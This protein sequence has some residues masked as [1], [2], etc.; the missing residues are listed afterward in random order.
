M[1]Y[2]QIENV[3]KRAWLTAWLED[4]TLAQHRQQ[5]LLLSLEGEKKEQ[6]KTDQAETSTEVVYGG[7]SP[8]VCAHEIKIHSCTAFPFNAGQLW[9]TRSTSSTKKV[10]SEW[11][12]HGAETERRSSRGYTRHI[13]LPDCSRIFKRKWLLLFE[14]LMQKQIHDSAIFLYSG[15]E[16]STPK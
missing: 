15:Q 6:K 8:Y 16:T 5:T 12:V 1:M 9:Q 3:C 10:L 13:V 7:Q 14:C 2:F 4:A 11:R